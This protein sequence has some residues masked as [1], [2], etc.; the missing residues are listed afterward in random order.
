MGLR[1]AVLVLFLAVAFVSPVYGIAEFG[2]CC[3]PAGACED[4]PFASCDSQSGLFVPGSLCADDPCDAVMAPVAS[5]EAAVLLVIA[6]LTVAIY[7]LMR[8]A[9][10]E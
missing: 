8:R 4:L 3:L 2:A 9:S 5:P 7:A 1:K 6:L 10:R